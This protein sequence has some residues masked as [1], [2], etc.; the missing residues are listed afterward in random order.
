MVSQRCII[1]ISPLPPPPPTTPHAVSE[2][3]A[4]ALSPPSR[5]VPLHK[6]CTA[7]FGMQFAPT[8]GNFY[9]TFT[10]KSVL[11]PWLPRCLMPTTFNK[12]V[13]TIPPPLPITTRFPRLTK[14]HEG[15][16]VYGPGLLMRV[17]LYAHFDM[18]PHLLYG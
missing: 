11:L 15:L 18:F 13:P 12:T 16:C 8:D 5:H 17:Q 14:L 10:L 6:G 7:R 1:L 9:L 4:L 2:G 3:R